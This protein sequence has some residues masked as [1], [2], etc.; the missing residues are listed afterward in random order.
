ML[1]ASLGPAEQVDFRLAAQSASRLMGGLVCTDGMAS[2]RDSRCLSTLSIDH[3]NM[4]IGYPA[5]TN[6]A[7]RKL[8]LLA[9][10][11]VGAGRRLG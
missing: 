4:M 9:G 7:Y 6:A 5:G 8:I 3:L 10:V 2:L 1:E 11:A